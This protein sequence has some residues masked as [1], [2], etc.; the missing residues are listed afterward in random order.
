MN[1]KIIKYLLLSIFFVQRINSEAVKTKRQCYVQFPAKDLSKNST[2]QTL[3]HTTATSTAT[4]QKET[5]TTSTS[6]TGLS[7]S[8][9][10][11]TTIKPE[12][13]T[14]PALN[15]SSDTFSDLAI[16]MMTQFAARN[17]SQN[18]LEFFINS[19]ERLRSSPKEP[20]SDRVKTTTSK[21]TLQNKPQLAAAAAF[22]SSTNGAINSGN[23]IVR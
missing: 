12:P 2:A 22:N 19:L 14:Q 20:L 10:H 11:Q 16:N 21:Q 6:A 9:Q 4:T 13:I 1:Q 3:H 23:M 17:F 15:N 7:Q 5:K 8:T 18:Q